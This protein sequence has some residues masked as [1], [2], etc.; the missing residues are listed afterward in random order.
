[1]V[2]RRPRLSESAP[3]SL[4]LPLPRV[5]S[6]GLLASPSTVFFGVAVLELLGTV[7]LV[8]PFATADGHFT[9]P[10][11]AFFTATSAITVTG[12]VVVDTSTYWSFWG[13]LTIMGLIFLGG[14]GWMTL[15]S[16]LLVVLGQRIT[17]PQRLAMREPLGVVQIGGVVRMLRNM[18]LTLVGIQVLGMVVLALRFH[19]AFTWPEAVW[20]G[21]FHSVSAFNNAG[22]TILPRSDNLSALTGDLA[23]L[24]VFSGLIILGG[25]SFGV[26]AELVRVRRFSRFSLDTKLVLVGSLLLWL[27]GALVVFAFESGNPATLGRLPLGEKV[28]NAVFLSVSARTAGFSTFPFGG[29]ELASMFF[30]TGL[31]FIGTASAS[32]GG[33]IRLNTMGVLVATVLASIR[34]RGEV[35]AFKREISQ[36]QVHRALAVGLLGIT[37]VFFAAFFL[38]F[39]ERR[40]FIDLLFETVSA[41]GTVGLST[42]VTPHLHLAGK[43][44]ISFTMLLGRLGP[45]ALA[46][47][48]AQR[49]RPALY[50]FARERV[51]IG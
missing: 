31:M 44:L 47:A 50:R 49:E 43:L 16:F 8:L 4:K 25:L 28:G 48:V 51:K 27:L 7:L 10:L 23:S 34:G 15:A 30:I 6:K 11:V 17:L 19:T 12:L 33:G 38:T 22:F 1:M 35:T 13:Q 37:L 45:L 14:V 20:L 18:V 41:F 3:I 29:M 9:A 32:T 40:G 39:I 2:V 24:G 46:L 5:P 36:E 21:A 42:G 26:M